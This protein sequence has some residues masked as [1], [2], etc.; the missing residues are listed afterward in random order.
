MK[1]ELLRSLL[2]NLNPELSHTFSLRALKLIEQLGLAKCLFGQTISKP[3]ELFGL[4]FENSIGLAAGLDKNGD[5]IDA[6]A[7]LG[8]GFLEIGT[9][10]PKPQSGN[11]KPRLFRLVKE[12]AIINRLGFNNKGVD[13]L[14]ARVKQ[15]KYQG[16]LGINI[17]KNATTPIE[18]ALADYLCCLEK[19]YPYASYVTVNISSPNTPEL[20][21]LQGDV[22]FNDL[23]FNLKKRQAEL[24][25]QHHR[26]V[27][28]LIKIAPDLNEIEVASMVK[29]MVAHNIDGVIATNTTLSREKISGSKFA[30]E[31][32]GVSG[33]PL[34]HA[35]TEIV[36]LLKNHLAGHHM[37]I[38]AAGGVMNT[39]Q[40]QAKFESGADLIQ[41]YTGLIYRGPQLIQDIIHANSKP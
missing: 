23:L 15:K 17:G 3:I 5:Y 31:Q 10:T 26:Y 28:M 34:F 32:G 39:K 6:L 29:S 33:E 8:F 4:T 9:V 2:F 40:A 35:A 7:A 22:Y 27:P 38:I 25:D 18:N 13:Y 41:L 19:V 30:E 36:Q 24:A 14:V 20:R 16:V 11:P 21:N 1:Y 37:P 12:Q